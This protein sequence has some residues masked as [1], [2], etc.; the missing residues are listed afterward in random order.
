MLQRCIL[1]SSAGCREMIG[2]EFNVLAREY[3]WLVV[4]AR[5]TGIYLNTESIRYDQFDEANEIDV[6]GNDGETRCSV[7]AWRHT[8]RLA[9]NGA[10]LLVQHLHR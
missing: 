10:R 1:Q 7:R 6:T 4:K 8:P 5:I 2:G 9:T 3:Q